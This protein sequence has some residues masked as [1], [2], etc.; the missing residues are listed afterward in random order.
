MIIEEMKQDSSNVTNP[1]KYHA[2]PS[3][4]IS[5]RKVI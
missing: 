4:A 3:F 5:Q 1:R 2:T